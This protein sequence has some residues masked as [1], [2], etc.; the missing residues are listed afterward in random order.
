MRYVILCCFASIAAASGSNA[1]NEFH[2]APNGVPAEPIR[3]YEAEFEA[4]TGFAWKFPLPPMGATFWFIFWIASFCCCAVKKV[5]RDPGAFKGP[6]VTPLAPAPP[7]TWAPP[8]WATAPPKPAPVQTAGARVKTP[9]TPSSFDIDRVMPP[10]NYWQNQDLTVDF[11]GRYM[12]TDRTAEVV[13][14]MLFHTFNTT[15]TRD[16]K[17]KMA[18]EFRL[19]RVQR[20]EDRNMWVRYQVAKER[21]KANRGYCEPVHR[22]SPGGQ[23]KTKLKDVI[24]HRLDESINEYYLWHGTTPAGANGISENGFDLSMAG[25]R[26]GTMFGDGAY[27]AECCSKSDEYA[28]DG[29]G[30][31]QGVYAFVLCRAVCGKMY[32]TETGGYR[33]VPQIHKAC[34]EDKTCDSCLGDREKAVNTYREFIVFDS[35]LIYPEFV[36]MYERIY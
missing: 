12:G 16:R 7:P 11:D 36:I 26:A 5:I 29:E 23:V 18:K 22:L 27:L 21:V 28:A 31:N 20:I 33:S 6:L 17:T 13:K 15:R 32:Y 30:I 1:T 2:D 4:H 34:L 14:Q 19:T 9:I 10:P 24:D 8:A 25:T 3:M 35:D